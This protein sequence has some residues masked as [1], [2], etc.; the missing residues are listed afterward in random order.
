MN[1]DTLYLV[2]S[3]GIISALVGGLITFVSIGQY[4]QKVDNCEKLIEKQGDKVDKLSERVATL[5]GGIDRD[6]DYYVKRKSPL[7]LTEKGKVLLLDSGGLEYIRENKQRLLS[8]IAN[9]KPKTSY[10]VQEYAKDVIN[11]QSNNDDFN[12]IK[13]YSF[14]EG[15]ELK[16]ILEVMRIQLRDEYFE[17]IKKNK[18]N[19]LL[20]RSN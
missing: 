11:E 14:K 5:E 18:D 12:N 8:S 15:L 9:K 6:R 20:F 2:I 1:S 4:K 19:D 17:E 13:E 16:H 7:S 3:S 10:D